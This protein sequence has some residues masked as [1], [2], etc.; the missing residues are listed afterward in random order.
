ML[1]GILLSIL[2]ICARE[3][4]PETRFL[5]RLS[6]LHPHVAENG[7]HPFYSFEGNYINFVRTLKDY[8][9]LGYSVP[10]SIGLIKGKEQIKTRS[11]RVVVEFQI[12]PTSGGGGYGFWISDDIF[13]GKYYGRNPSYSGIGVIIDTSKKPFVKV[14][15][16]DDSI[17]SNSVYPA[18]GNGMNTL[19]IESHGKRLIITMVV[20]NREYT[21]Y[22]GASPVQTNHIFGISTST[23]DAGIPLILNSI[24]GYALATAKIPYVKG[25]T[26]KSRGLVVILGA[27]CVAGLIYYLY[28][29]QNKDKEFSLKG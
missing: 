4:A 18:F 15:S 8:T 13:S 14:V 10:N 26:R 29:K 2:N 24:H 21:I 5:E 27:A 1:L 22:S 19:V 7:R 6:L 12:T 20:G 28:Q 9:Q 17:K 11:F 25:E 23:G 3:D 16:G